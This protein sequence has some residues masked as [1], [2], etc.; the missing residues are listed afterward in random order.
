MR[1]FSP[2]CAFLI[3]VLRQIVHRIDP[4]A[5]CSDLKVTVV[6]G[7]AAGTARTGDGLALG[8]V[9]TSGNQYTGIMAVVGHFA[10]AVVDYDQIAIAPIGSGH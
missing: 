10:V 8:Y 7:G 2:N 4:D 6:P 3:P 1:T 9:V 5:P